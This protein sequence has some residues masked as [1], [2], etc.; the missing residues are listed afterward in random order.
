[1]SGSGGLCHSLG[2][3]PRRGNSVQMAM[4]RA[5]KTKAGSWAFQRTL[6]RIDRP[7]YR[8][9]RGRFTIPDLATGVPV[10]MLTTTGAKSGL[11]RTMPVAGIPDSNSDDIFIMGTNYA[12]PKTPA[13]VFNLEAEPRC[14]VSWRGRSAR[15]IA[16]PV[17]DP[18]EREHAWSRASEFYLGFTEYRKRIAHREV[19]I[20]RLSSG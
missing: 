16:H 6:Y 13:W 2:F 14:E 4:Q 15:A 3:A 17:T 10:I 5:A 8:W 19:R 20:F 12:Q 1:M 7:L 18:T 9:S 11:A